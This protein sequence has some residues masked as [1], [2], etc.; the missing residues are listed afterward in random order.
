MRWN[1]S[2]SNGA[3]CLCF[4][5]LE[6]L[7]E[8]NRDSRILTHHFYYSEH[9]C[10]HRLVKRNICQATNKYYR[11][12]EKIE[13]KQVVVLSYLSERCTFSSE[14]CPQSSCFPSPLSKSRPG[15]LTFVP[16]RSALEWR[17][18]VFCQLQWLITSVLVW[19]FQV[20]F[21]ALNLFRSALVWR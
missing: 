6:N 12:R 15:V 9:K 8:I 21:R 10:C 4:D 11:I 20:L 3:R 13:F 5:I 16:L 7:F 18:T 19:L 17:S 14:I 1:S 2:E